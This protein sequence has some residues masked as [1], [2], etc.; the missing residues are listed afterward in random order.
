MHKPAN[1]VYGAALGILATVCA[2][3]APALSQERVK[4]GEYLAAIMDCAG[5]HTTGA[6]VGK[7]DPSRHLAGSEVGFKI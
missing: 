1:K 2:W 7:P 4:R 5:C 6:L 3:T